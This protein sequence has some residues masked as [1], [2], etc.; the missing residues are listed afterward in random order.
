[1]DDYSSDFG[2]QLRR[3]TQMH[4]ADI[5]VGAVTSGVAAEVLAL[6]GAVAHASERKF[7]P[8]ASFAAGVAVGKLQAGGRILTDQDVT[9]FLAQ[10]RV[11]L[12]RP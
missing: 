8:I 1:M 12:D 4:G 10:L 11:Q 9:H 6:A 7:A 5:E 2:V 3:L